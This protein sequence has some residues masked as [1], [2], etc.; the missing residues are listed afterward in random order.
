MNSINPC[1]AA[2]YTARS[3]AYTGTAGSTGAWPAGPNSVL[4]W[5]TTDAHVV[6]GEGLTA[7]TAAT[8]IPAYT[9]IPFN[10]PEGTGGQWRVSAIQ[11]ASG[12][13]VYAKPLE[14]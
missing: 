10:V 4:V 13:T 7:T 6:V 3:V 2:Q 9:P 11:V 14:N 12:G 5:S 1:Q 8:P